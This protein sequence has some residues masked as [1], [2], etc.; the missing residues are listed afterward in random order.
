VEEAPVWIR[1][2]G[3]RS[4]LIVCSPTEID[5]LAIGHLLGGGWIRSTADVLALETVAGPGGAC[6]VDVRI[7]DRIA[8]AATAR[9]RH[10][11]EHGCGPRHVLDCEDGRAALPDRPHTSTTRDLTAPFRA[12]FAAADLAAPAGGV[13]AAALCDGTSLHHVSVDVARHCAVDRAVGLAMLAG[14]DLA[15]SGLVLTSRISG[16]I[17]L[18]AVYAGV[19]WLASRSLATPLARE[20]AAAARL[21]LLERAARVRSG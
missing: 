14:D 1:I 11:L 17:A 21:P 7:D 4:I 5:A 6:G 2:N 16:A 10:M 13:H 9:H 12:L 19:A 18:K 15:Q 3:S 20:I 8:A